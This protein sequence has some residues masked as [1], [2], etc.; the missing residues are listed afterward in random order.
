MNDFSTH[1]IESVY[2]DL[3]SKMLTKQQK[4]LPGDRISG[5]QMVPEIQIVKH[6]RVR[7]KC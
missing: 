7:I 4:S 2:V 1:E 5:H 6:S 3:H